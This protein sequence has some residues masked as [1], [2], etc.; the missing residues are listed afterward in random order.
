MAHPCLQLQE[1]TDGESVPEG[2]E[3]HTAKWATPVLQKKVF[4]EA[5]L[6]FLRLD[7]PEDIFKKV[8]PD[9]LKGDINHSR[10]YPSL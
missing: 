4:G 8:R 5:W 6:G 1:G 3:M 10:L 2:A 7:V 9:F